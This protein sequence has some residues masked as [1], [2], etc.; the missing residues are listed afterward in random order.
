[1]FGPDSRT[2]GLLREFG[3]TFQYTNDLTA[4]MLVPNWDNVNLGRQT[5]KLDAKIEEYARRGEKKSVAPAPIFRE[6]ALGL[7]VLDGLQRMC[8]ELFFLHSTHFS[9][10][11]VETDSDI[12][13]AQIRVLANHKLNGAPESPEWTR[14]QAVAILCLDKGLGVREVANMGDWAWQ[15]VEADKTFL[16]TGFALR[17]QG[18]PEL[19]KGV[20]L[21][22]AEHME[23]KDLE[24]APEPIVEFACDLKRGKFTNGQSKEPVKKFFD[25]SRKANANLRKQLVRNLDTFR[26]DPDTMARL[27]GRRRTKLTHDINL[28]R[29][30]KHAQTVA[31]EVL[32]SGE[33]I[34]YIE[35]FYQI[36][37]SI[38][39]A[40]KAI[41]KKSRSKTR[42]R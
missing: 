6:V 23:M 34:P 17:Q 24:I 32:A 27:D 19:S 15:D 2:E 13:A 41:E 26:A 7:D 21:T 20:V 8:A 11:I 22:L 4:D 38:R 31:Q 16:V 25:V 35:E 14:R 39:D 10:Y 28:R 42:K 3:V 33:Q 12:K 30:L 29:A 18:A 5:P 36:S 40:L 9:G 1:M 37:N